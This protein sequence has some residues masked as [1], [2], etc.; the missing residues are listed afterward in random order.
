MGL[1]PL[2]IHWPV[3]LS[4]SND[5]S[6]ATLDSTHSIPAT[7]FNTKCYM[8]CNSISDDPFTVLLQY[9][10]YALS[11]LDGISVAIFGL[12]YTKSTYAAKNSWCY[13]ELNIWQCFTILIPDAIGN[14]EDRLRWAIKYICTAF[15]FPFPLTYRAPA[16][17]SCI[18]TGID[19]QKSRLVGRAS[20]Y[21][22][23][24]KKNQIYLP[25]TSWTN[26]CC[27][28]DE[29]GVGDERWPVDFFK[30]CL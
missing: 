9:L 21:F 22:S 27:S 19:T 4:A 6:F 10:K 12:G 18:S 17:T 16:D 24:F 29:Q 20:K 28:S 3:A 26:C 23:K 30:S 8:A 7:I 2:G 15:P 1:D 11:G 14:L 5:S 13:M 25:Y